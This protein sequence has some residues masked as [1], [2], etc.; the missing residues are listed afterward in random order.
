MMESL[1]FT[2]AERR[3]CVWHWQ[4]AMYEYRHGFWNTATKH[5]E[6][7][8]LDRR[9]ICRAQGE[10]RMYVCT[11]GAAEQHIMSVC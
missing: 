11:A 4:G 5:T 9:K 8:S 6:K 3:R 7:C 1:E 10:S 2:P